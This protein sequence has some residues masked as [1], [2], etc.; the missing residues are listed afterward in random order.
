MKI[1]KIPFEKTGRFTQIVIDYLKGDVQLEPYINYTPDL[2]SFDKAIADKANEEYDADLLYNTLLQQYTG[3]EISD[4]V[5]HNIESFKNKNTFSVVTAHQLNIFTGPLYV[6]YKTVSTIQLCAQLNEKYPDKHFVPMFWLGSEDHDIEEINHFQLFGKTYTWNAKQGGACGKY[7]PESLVEIIEELKAV[8]GDSENAKKLITIFTKAYLEND[9]LADATR[10]IMNSIFGQYGLVVVDGDAKGFKDAC[11][12]III[13]ELFNHTS[14]KIVNATLQKFPYPAQATPREINLFYLGDNVR[15]RIVFNNDKN[16]Y[17]VLNTEITFTADALHE[18]IENE[19]EC[20]SPN[21]ILR[22]LCQQ[23]VLP[24]VAFIGGGGELAYWLQ[25]K[26]LF[27]NYHI[28]FPMLLLRDSYVLID[29]NAEK[30]MIKFEYENSDIF[31]EE[32]VLI[33]T[34]VKVHSS[35]EVNLEL[36]KSEIENI[37][38]KIKIAAQHIDPSLEKTVLGE[39][40]SVINSLQKLE[41]KL[42]KAEKAK[43][44]LELGQITALL[45]KLFPSDGLQ[46]R[47]DNFMQYY[48]KYGDKLIENL[49]LASGQPKPKFTLLRT[50]S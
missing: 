45:S 14:E 3:V 6:I 17:S 34:Y 33:N 21:V 24:A 38:E 35:A 32:N 44:E 43:M 50:D 25:L 13:D 49:L 9:N 22:P 26:A 27:E 46:E 10:V 39:R 2:N 5:K 11:K 47:T 31:K 29:G 18:K 48:I 23:K 15:E 8:L 16:V 20:F 4:K 12:D 30:K 1:E 28:V 42:L 37:F 7:R 19:P 36:Q 40:Q 41:S